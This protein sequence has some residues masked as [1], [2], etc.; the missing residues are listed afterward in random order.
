VGH[1]TL[2]LIGPSGAGKTSLL[3]AVAGLERPRAGRIARGPEVWF[4]AAGGRYLRPEQRAVGYLPQ[5]Y[6]LFPHLTVAGNVRFASGR[7]RP[8]LLERMGVSHLAGA[9]PSELSGGERQRVALARALARDPRALLLDEPF[10]A[11]DAITRAQVRDELAQTLGELR[12]P[13][14]L[15]THAYD[16]AAALADRVAVLDRGRVAQVGRPA[17]L[18]AAPADALVATLT[19]ANVLAG[20]ATP[21]G[22]GSWIELDGGG[23]IRS[24]SA[25]VSGRVQ[26]AVY[27]WELALTDS[28]AAELVDRVIS[29]RPTGGALSVRLTRLSVRTS[30]ASA[31]ALDLCEGQAVG[32]AVDP[33]TVRFLGSWSEK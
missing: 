25:P 10:A 28:A 11:L 19:G 32:V 8:D 27:P 14:L 18:L 24:A 31:A 15:V 2:A 33:E 9:R 13:T 1:E 7:D 29:I 16:D 6:G 5:D 21:D 17:D 20:D 26:V 30:P 12:L 4:D 22:G 23:R 3:R